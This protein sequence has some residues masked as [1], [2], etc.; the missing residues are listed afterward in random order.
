[1]D[2]KTAWKKTAATRVEKAKLSRDELT[3]AREIIRAGNSR[4][5]PAYETIGK[6]GRE[7]NINQ[8]R[9]QRVYVTESKR[10]DVVATRQLGKGIGFSKYSVILSPNACHKCQQMTENGRKI[11]TQKDITK[12]GYGWFVPFHPHCYCIVVPEE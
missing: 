10:N 7:L 6:V 3:K 11:F 4:S 12:G 8:Y 5:V 2:F 1:M 9:A